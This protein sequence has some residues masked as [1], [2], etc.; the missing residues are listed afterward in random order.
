MSRTIIGCNFTV[1]TGTLG[2]IRDH[3][4]DSGTCGSSFKDSGKNGHFI[5][6]LSGSGIP[7]AAGLPPVKEGLDICFRKRKAGRTAVY[8]YTKGFPVR[9]SP[10]CYFKI[11][12]KSISCHNNIPPAAVCCIIIS[13]QI[14]SCKTW[15]KQHR[16]PVN[17]Y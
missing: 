2:G 11:G 10:G 13:S 6:L 15:A 8:D 12:S 7:A 17:C 3:Q 5:P 1:I 14:Y 4:T 9:F 16:I